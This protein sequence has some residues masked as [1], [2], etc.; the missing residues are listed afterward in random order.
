MDDAEGVPRWVKA[1]AIAALV[2]LAVLVVLHLAGGGMGQ[3]HGQ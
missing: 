2:L 1:F 3:H